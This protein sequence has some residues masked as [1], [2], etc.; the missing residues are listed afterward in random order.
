MRRLSFALSSC[1]PFYKWLH[2]LN[3]SG[4]VKLGSPMGELAGPLGLTCAPAGAMQA[5]NRRQAALGESQRGFAV[6]TYGLIESW[7]NTHNLPWLPP[8]GSCRFQRL[9]GTD[10]SD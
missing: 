3:L 5:S 8:G 2:L 7:A 10:E 1:T 6:G 9:F 4:E